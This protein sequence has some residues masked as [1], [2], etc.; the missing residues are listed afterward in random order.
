MATTY[1][2]CRIYGLMKCVKRYLAVS[3][4]GIPHLPLPLALPVALPLALPVALPLAQPVVQHPYLYN[5]VVHINI[6]SMR[7]WINP[8]PHIEVINHESSKNW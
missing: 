8:P 3:R 7:R 5:E 1:L 2:K 6:Y 4:G